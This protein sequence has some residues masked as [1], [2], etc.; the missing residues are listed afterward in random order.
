VAGEFVSVTPNCAGVAVLLAELLALPTA[1]FGNPLMHPYLGQ[2]A[3]AGLRHSRAPTQKLPNLHIPLPLVPEP[4][5][6]G[7][8][9]RQRYVWSRE[10]Q[11]GFS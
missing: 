10:R 4:S 5:I 3:K 7:V 11:F 1:R 9:E 2:K 6:C 8:H